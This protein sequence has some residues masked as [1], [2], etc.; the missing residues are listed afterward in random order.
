MIQDLICS[1]CKFSV[2]GLILFSLT[3][4]E[5]CCSLQRELH[6]Q[7]LQWSTRSS[8]S[9]SLFSF[10]VVFFITIIVIIIIIIIFQTTRGKKKKGLESSRNKFVFRWRVLLY[11]G[12]VYSQFALKNSKY[13]AGKAG[14]IKVLAIYVVEHSPFTL[15]WCQEP[16]TVHSIL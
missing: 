4:K 2:E 13:K 8:C 6:Q 9:F 1:Q 7:H 5:V 12:S 15:P 10:F 11:E 3:S 16:C 14:I